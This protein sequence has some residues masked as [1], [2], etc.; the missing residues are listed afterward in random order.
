[1]WGWIWGFPPNQ[2][3]CENTMTGTAGL[4]QG[5]KFRS[6]S[7]C[8][9]WGPHI[10]RLPFAAVAAGSHRF[11][12]S[13]LSGCRGQI[14]WWWITRW[15][16][17]PRALRRLVMR[18]DAS[19]L[20]LSWKKKKSTTRFTSTSGLYHVLYSVFMGWSVLSTQLIHIFL[21]KYACGLCLSYFSKSL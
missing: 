21:F 16:W 1:M 14:S 20:G 8:S 12:Q 2:M 17:S 7:A 19:F 10:W 13:I 18:S 15:P 6:M 4:L 11:Q 3:K 5:E 9:C